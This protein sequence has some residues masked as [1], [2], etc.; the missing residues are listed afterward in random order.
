MGQVVGTSHKVGHLFELTSLHLPV[1]MSTATSFHTPS[2]TLRT[3]HYHLGHVSISR[4][5]SLISSSHLGSIKQESLDCIS[6][7]LRKLSQLTFNDSDSTS[8]TPFDLVHFDVCGP[9][10]TP[11]PTPTIGDH[12]CWVFYTQ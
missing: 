7:Q 1:N 6:C 11:T 5:R 4:L 10:P 12:V 3:W 8:S 2:S 9:T